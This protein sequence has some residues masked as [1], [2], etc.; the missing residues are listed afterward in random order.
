M[1]KPASLRQAIEA[2]MPDI[3]ANPDKLKVYIDSGHIVATYSRA[4]SY[5]YGYTLNLVIIDFGDSPE[6][7]M[8]AILIWLRSQQPEMLANQDLMRDGFSFEAEP[9]SNTTVDIAIKLRL[10]ERV[11]VTSQDGQHVATCLPE[12][13]PEFEG[14]DWQLV[15]ADLDPP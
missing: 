10:T 8:L 1:K 9:I 6:L 3:K 12:P 14:I 13:Q 15:I 11:G 7:L 5:E 4:L 2:A